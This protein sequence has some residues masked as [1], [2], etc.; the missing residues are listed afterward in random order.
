[1]F[2]TYV[3]MAA[4]FS[5]GVGLAKAIVDMYEGITSAF[6]AYV[7][8]VLTMAILVNWADSINILARLGA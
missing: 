1:M 5:F 4:L 3:G 8:I 7:I 2:W 6:I